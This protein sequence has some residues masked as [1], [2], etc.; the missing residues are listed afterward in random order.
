[1]STARS[2]SPTE[3]K[4]TQELIIP[5]T[6]I[7]S[8]TSLPAPLV[9]EPNAVDQFTIIITGSTT[10]AMMRGEPL[11]LWGALFICLSMYIN[12]SPTPPGI[13]QTLFSVVLLIGSLSLIYYRI[14]NG[15]IIRK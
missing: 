8:A 6:D 4:E 3:K 7:D 14:S 15:T 12:R 11:I 1:M 2:K 5:E 13:N 10:F 9:E